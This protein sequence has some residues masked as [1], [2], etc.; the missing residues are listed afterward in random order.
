[1]LE[2]KEVDDFGYMY[3]LSAIELFL[4]V[5]FISLATMYQG[6]QTNKTDQDL[7]RLLLAANQDIN[8]MKIIAS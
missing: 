7:K 3:T 8:R 5:V 4:T 2:M 6:I 1:M